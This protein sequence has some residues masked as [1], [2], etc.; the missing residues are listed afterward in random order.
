MGPEVTLPPKVQAEQVER[1]RRRARPALCPGCLAAVLK[2]PDADRAAIPAVVDLAPITREPRSGDYAL[3]AGELH[4][5][6]M[7]G[8]SLAGRD[9]H[10]AHACDGGRL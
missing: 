9:V 1:Q 3:F 2:G 8:P 7:A 5:L 4:R 6:D 10:A